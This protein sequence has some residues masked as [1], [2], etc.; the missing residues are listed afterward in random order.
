MTSPPLG[1]AAATTP[2]GPEFGGTAMIAL[3]PTPARAAGLG[4]TVDH[5]GSPPVT[6][7]AAVLMIGAA[8]LLFFGRGILNAIEIDRTGGVLPA[9]DY[10]AF[11]GVQDTVTSLAEI[12]GALLILWL[13]CRHLQVPRELAGIPRYP[14]SPIPA[15]ASLGLA[16][17]GLLLANLLL[18]ALQGPEPN[19]DAGGVVGN[20]WAWLSLLSDLNAGVVEEIVIVAIPV[21]V[22][23]RAGWHPAAIIA[24]SMALR[25]PYHIY[26]GAW[27]SLPWAML[28][29][30]SYAVAFLYLRRLAPLIAFHAAYDAYIG[31]Q[32][33]Y[34]DAGGNT[35]L[36]VGA[37]LALGLALRITPD[38]RRRLNPAAPTGDAATA[39]YVLFRGDRRNPAILA[40]GAIA[41][42]AIIAVEISLAPDAT[43]KLI[44]GLLVAL[45]I[46]VIT[47]VLWSG[48]TASNTIVYRDLAGAITGVIRWHTTYT[49]D[50]NIDTITNGVDELAAIS[51]VARLDGNT[52]VLGS[53]KARRNRLAAA[54]WKAPRRSRFRRIRIPAERAATLGAAADTSSTETSAPPAT[55]GAAGE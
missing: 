14:A 34:G 33:A 22:G 35:V 8:Y 28:W 16:F 6:T 39:R 41:I 24:V 48:W 37:I 53:T 26:H 13:F 29:G 25:W 40:R 55:D 49:G 27:A 45:T 38:R 12:V 7:P 1:T 36:I 15:L 11:L 47:R 19:A 20:G 51:A 23:R 17:I 4:S 21:L 18:N 50:T 52:V 5:P 9:V 30:G 32:S 43:T 42:A 2:A 3:V 46:G 54:G 44:L 10:S 31:I